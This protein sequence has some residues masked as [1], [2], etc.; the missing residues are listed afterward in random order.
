MDRRAQEKPARVLAFRPSV[1]FA[2][3]SDWMRRTVQAQQP[4]SPELIEAWAA[5]IDTAEA[6]SRLI[7]AGVVAH[8][9]TPEAADEDAYVVNLLVDTSFTAIDRLASLASDA[10]TRRELVEIHTTVHAL[11]AGLIALAS[12]IARP[13]HTE[14]D[15][16]AA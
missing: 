14:G 4:A 12:G 1:A 6:R 2:S 11:R 16:H 10:A 13:Q 3:V 7:E 5:A 8:Q 15:D 9:I